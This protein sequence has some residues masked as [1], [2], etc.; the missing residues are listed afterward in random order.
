M[1]QISKSIV[2]EEKYEE[3]KNFEDAYFRNR[4]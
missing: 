1:L 3:N 2:K 4:I